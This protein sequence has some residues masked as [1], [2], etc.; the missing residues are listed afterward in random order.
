MNLSYHL[1]SKIYSITA[2]TLIGLFMISCQKDDAVPSTPTISFNAASLV[3][4]QNTAEP[5]TAT[6][7]LS[8]SDPLQAEATVTIGVDKSSTAAADD[9]ITDPAISSG[10]FTLDLAKGATAASFTLTPT[11]Y[12]MGN[13]TI[14]FKIISVTGGVKPGSSGLTTT[15]TLKKSTALA[16]SL[17]T[18]VTSLPDFGMTDNGTTSISKTYTVSGSYLVSDISVTASPN[19]QVS[20]D[21][22]TFNDSLGIDYNQANAGP[23]KVYVRFAPTTGKNQDLT[24]TLTQTTA[25]AQKN[26]I[27][28]K[29]T[30][31]GNATGDLLFNENFD[32]GSVPGNLT[33]LSSWKN[34]SGT[35]TPVQYVTGGLSFTGY[36]G[37]GTGGAA[38]IENGSGSREDI[39]RPIP[40]QSSGTVYIALLMNTSVAEANTTATGGDFPIALTDNDGNYFNRLYVKD[41]GNGN[42]T[43]GIAKTRSGGGEQVY[44]ATAFKYNTTYLVVIKYDFSEK[45]TSMFVLE[46]NLPET[47]PGT[48]DA[49][50]NTGND[51]AT[52]DNIIIRQSN[53]GLTAAIDDIRIAKTWKDVLG[54]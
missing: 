42:L 13:K 31:S 39:T 2:I 23:V 21:N 5:L 11:I 15:V 14:L 4:D 47:E 34:Y 29:G 10:S 7:T 52:F 45:E 54:L 33:A 22:V 27:T 3:I 53:H 20:L 9:Y 16:P 38:T 49:T 19:F 40:S 8:L 35:G 44:A 26:M 51:P 46:N 1:S 50:A 18:S 32:Y 36:G 30:E 37:S 28:V 41:D 17:K 12:L 43:L 6:V 25:G 48:P 24:G